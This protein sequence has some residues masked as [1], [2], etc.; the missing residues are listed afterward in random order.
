MDRIV[1]ELPLP[2][3]DADTAPALLRRFGHFK[4]AVMNLLQREPSKRPSMKAFLKD[5][6]RVLMHT[7]RTGNS[8]VL[9]TSPNATTTTTTVATEG[10]GL[11]ATLEATEEVYT[12]E[13]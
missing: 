5:C 10:M 9:N 3:E 7:T 1:G 4:L 6:N 12:P 11:G 8:A 2:W 13:D